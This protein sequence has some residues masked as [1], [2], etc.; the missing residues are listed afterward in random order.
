MVRVLSAQYRRF[1]AVRAP[2]T[3]LQHIGTA[4]TA[5]V[6]AAAICRDIQDRM[7]LLEALH[8]LAEV[9]R[10][11]APTYIPA[12]M[13]SSVLESLLQEPGWNYKQMTNLEADDAMK[14]ILGNMAVIGDEFFRNPMAPCAMPQN[15]LSMSHF[16][17]DATFPLASNSGTD[18][19]ARV[20]EANYSFDC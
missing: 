16:E 12:E 1:E 20:D 4:V 17:R 3:Q 14:A 10:A 11:I 13:I 2:Q 9:A 6:S 19:L 7:R 15:Q 5:L 8:T 18:I